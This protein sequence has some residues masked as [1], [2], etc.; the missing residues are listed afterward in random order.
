MSRLA[1]L[2]QEG[3]HFGE[4]ARAQGVV[5]GDGGGLGIGVLRMAGKRSGANALGTSFRRAPPSPD[6]PAPYGVN[7]CDEENGTA[8]VWL[9]AKNRGRCLRAAVK[10]CGKGTRLLAVAGGPDNVETARPV[11]VVSPYVV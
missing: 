7:A 11:S 4:L 3:E 9:R 10:C 6:T 8:Q 1:G 2:D 5:R